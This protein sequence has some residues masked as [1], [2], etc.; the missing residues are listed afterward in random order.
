MAES[1]YRRRVEESMD[2][3]SRATAEEWSLESTED[4]IIKNEVFGCKPARHHMDI[5][6]PVL[7]MMRVHGAP[8]IR[9]DSRTNPN[10]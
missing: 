4:A 5:G 3:A 2:G 1:R 6:I 7:N 9:P 8:N 10:V